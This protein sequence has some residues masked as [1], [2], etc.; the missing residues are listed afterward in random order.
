MNTTPDQ[1]DELTCRE[2]VEL[3]TDYLEGALSPA[4]HAQFE[5][6]LSLCEGCQIYLEQMRQTLNLLGTLHE[7]VIPSEGKEQL[8]QVFRAWKQSSSRDWEHEFFT[9]AVRECKEGN[10]I[11]IP[12]SVGHK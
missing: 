9:I 10:L 11:I 5:F 8:L 6:H 1:S 4:L 12:E 2:F 7:F 3:V